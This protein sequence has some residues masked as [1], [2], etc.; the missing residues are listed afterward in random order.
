VTVEPLVEADVSTL[1]FCSILMIVAPVPGVELP[2]LAPVNVTVPKFASGTRPPPDSKSSTIHSAFSPHSEGW[3]LNV[4]ETVWPLEW[5]MIV[6]VPPVSEVAVTVVVIESPACTVMPV[7]STEAA[8]NHSNHA[9][10]E[11][12]PPFTLKST[13]VWRMAVWQVSPSMPTHADAK[14]PPLAPEGSLGVGTVKVPVTVLK[15]FELATKTAPDQLELNSALVELVCADSS[16]S[17]GSL[18]FD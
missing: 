3:L 18:G 8:G 14:W 9:S 1:L 7:K 13:P 2:A 10:N 15:V 5:L 4:C 17:A 12:L 6:A 11:V 16:P